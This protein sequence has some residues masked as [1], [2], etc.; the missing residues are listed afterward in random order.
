MG[1]IMCAF[2]FQNGFFHLWVLQLSAV[3]FA[4]FFPNFLLV[5]SLL[6]LLSTA[7]LVFQLMLEYFM[8]IFFMR[9]AATEYFVALFYQIQSIASTVPF[10]NL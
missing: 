6:Y 4:K 8:Y 9:K 10:R 1:L 3:Y 2:F 7:T 5:R